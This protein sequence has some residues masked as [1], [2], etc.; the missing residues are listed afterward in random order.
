M[1]MISICG[2]SIMLS[3]RPSLRCL[4]AIRKLSMPHFHIA[5]AIASTEQESRTSHA[6]GDG[7]AIEVDMYSIFNSNGLCETPFN[8]NAIQRLHYR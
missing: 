4:Q 5:T 8:F 7:D 2:P 1:K 6:A 3:S